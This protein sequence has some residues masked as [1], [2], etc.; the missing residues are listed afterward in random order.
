MAAVNGVNGVNF[1]SEQ[2][3]Q[4]SG[5]GIPI[6][7]TGAGALGGYLMKKGLSKDAFESSLKDGSEIKY[8]SELT[9]DEQ[10][11]VD[12]A[13][14]E[15]QGVKVE[16]KK[17]ADDAK[18]KVEG[19]G[20]EAK[21]AA[22]SVK[23]S[24]SA[25]T[26]KTIDKIFGNKEELKWDEY[27]RR[28]YGCN[29]LGQFNDRIKAEHKKLYSDGAKRHERSK[30]VQLNKEINTLKGQ[31]HNHTKSLGELE[32]MIKQNQSIVD[33]ENKIKVAEFKLNNGLTDSPES[34]Q[35]EI[36]NLKQ[37]LANQQKRYE[38]V[39]EEYKKYSDRAGNIVT[40]ADKDFALDMDTLKGKVNDNKLSEGFIKQI[41]HDAR[42]EI[43]NEI[44][45]EA[46]AKVV[47]EN[48]NKKG[49][50]PLGK[51]ELADKIEAAKKQAVADKEALIT[52]YEDLCV[53]TKT[54]EVKSNRIL[55]EFSNGRKSNCEIAQKQLHIDERELGKMEAK[56]LE[57]EKD[58][59][60]IKAAK[61][62]GTTISKSTAQEVFDS[63]AV[64]SKSK[65][66]KV[67]A[68]KA[69]K[70]AGK[71]EKAIGT[72]LE[73]AF[74][75]VKGKFAGTHSGMRALIGAGIGLVAGV[76][77]KFMVDGSK[78]ESV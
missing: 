22:T 30:G 48:K 28:K 11:A 58:Y 70:V 73:K 24:E 23:A 1:G 40:D 41:R 72:A 47:N 56:S 27:L 68:T 35:S 76:I 12:A 42:K 14:K 66:T 19:E 50:K 21:K 20:E 39:G 43:V 69:E 38:K 45:A 64:K 59:D 37:S 13:K 2:K 9:A 36:D 75:A 29:N 62:D 60:L 16:D 51:K 63:A 46:E 33:T 74:D 57:M 32:K 44:E 26:G 25:A 8:K 31:A 6:I 10:K 4:T 67:A 7:A 18:A 3:K 34:L 17:P 61:T 54:A 5:V 55:K 77:I 49:T 65:V 78:S 15:L 53:E 52:K 71:E